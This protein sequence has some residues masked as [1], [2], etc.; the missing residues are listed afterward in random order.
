M[1][2]LDRRPLPTPTSTDQHSL[3]RALYLLFC[4]SLWLTSLFLSIE[5]KQQWTGGFLVPTLLGR[6]LAEHLLSTTA[7]SW[8]RGLIH[9]GFSEASKCSA[10]TH[11]RPA[12]RGGREGWETGRGETTQAGAL[13]TKFCKDQQGCTCIRA[14]TI[15]AQ[16]VVYPG[17]FKLLREP[18]ARSPRREPIGSIRHGRVVF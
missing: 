17:W 12:D 15:R 16:T 4:F 18:V 7:C 9:H 8:W 10:N 6:R 3:P 14:Q 13:L 1:A 11:P 5:R 2:I